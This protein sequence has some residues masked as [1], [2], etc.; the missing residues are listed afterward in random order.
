MLLWECE[1]PTRPTPVQPARIEIIGGN[2]QSGAVGEALPIAPAVRVLDIHDKP[3]SNVVVLWAADDDA[4]VDNALPSDA[5]GV[6]RA[7]W[8]LG[9]RAGA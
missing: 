1:E 6:A 7:T 8:V 2:Q 3:A 5:S 4:R 9:T